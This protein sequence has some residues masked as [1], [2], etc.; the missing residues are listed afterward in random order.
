MNS[1][2]NKIVFIS[3]ATS[4]IGKSCAYAFAKEGANLI[5]NARRINLI[6]E[7]GDDIR[8]KF[9]VKVYGFKMDVRNKDE[10][11][12]SIDSMPDEWKSVDILIN[13]AGLAVGFN[14]LQED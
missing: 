12:H 8:N 4:G 10:V 1:L 6:N 13:N 14:K 3:G 9:G 7:I 11:D 5:I 2:K